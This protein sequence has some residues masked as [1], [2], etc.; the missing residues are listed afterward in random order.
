MADQNQRKTSRSSRSGYRGGQGGDRGGA[1]GGNRG[2]SRQSQSRESD[3]MFEMRRRKAALDAE[4]E[5]LAL[6]E[7]AQ[8]RGLDPQ[9]GQDGQTTQSGPTRQAS[10]PVTNRPAS[11][12]EQTASPA[13]EEAGSR[14]EPS[15]NDGGQVQE[16]DTS[17]GGPAKYKTQ[18]KAAR[19]AIARQKDPKAAKALEEANEKKNENRDKYVNNRDMNENPFSNANKHLTAKQRA[20]MDRKHHDRFA[21]EMVRD[22][23]SPLSNG[24]D[25]NSM[26]SVMM[27][28]LHSII[29]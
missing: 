21:H 16:Q 19:A 9:P 7:E 12:Q 6:N 28:Q 3:A 5:Q 10:S 29:I 8:R 1:R 13:A 18:S 2:G 24:A 25:F 11:E 14:T 4:M 20:D 22:A 26:T 23:I 15:N 17:V 27:F